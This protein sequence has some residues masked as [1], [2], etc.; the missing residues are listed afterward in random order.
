MAQSRAGNT[1]DIYNYGK[2]INQF[3]PNMIKAIWQYE[4]INKK[5]CRQKMSDYVQRNLY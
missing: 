3:L 4:W 2:Y 5:I 1:W